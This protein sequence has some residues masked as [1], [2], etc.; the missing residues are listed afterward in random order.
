MVHRRWASLAGAR[1]GPTMRVETAR[2]SHFVPLA[3]VARTRFQLA[4]AKNVFVWPGDWDLR[5]Q[6]VATEYPALSIS[7]RSVLQVFGD[8]IPFQHCDEYRRLISLLHESRTSPRGQSVGQ[9]DEYF[10]SLFRLASDMQAGKFC[11]TIS[12]DVAR[13]DEIGVAVG[14]QGELLKMEDK[15]GGTHRFA[16]ARV[17]GI[18]H[19]AVQIVAVH[20][21]FIESQQQMKAAKT[22]SQMLGALYGALND[23]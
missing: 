12:F 11:P 7:Y 21:L 13:H 2:L 17:L 5:A 19:V 3:A 20:P 22:P 1:T 10:R 18:S 9:V 4:T 16:L 6:E 15:F 14:R 8:N 23:G